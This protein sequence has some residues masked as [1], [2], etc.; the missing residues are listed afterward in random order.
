M[1]KSI[2]VAATLA[3][4]ATGSTL[5]RWAAHA[6][7]PPHMRQPAADTD[8]LPL[9]FPPF[10]RSPTRNFAPGSTRAWPRICR[11]RAD[12]PQPRA[13]SFDNT[14]IAMGAQRPLARAHHHGVVQPARFGRQPGAPEVCRPITPHAW[15]RTRRGL[16]QPQAVRR[17][18][19][20]CTPRA[21]QRAGRRPALDRA[22]HRHFVRAGARLNDEQRPA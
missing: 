2:A 4:F 9:Q 7:P 8:P 13:A 1:R 16:A 10:D 19:R 15:P 18:C 17:A 22:H 12:R 20:P 6:A 11:D 5:A 21:K 3:A 14:I